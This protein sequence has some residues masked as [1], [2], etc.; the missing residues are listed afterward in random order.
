MIVRIV[1]HNNEAVFPFKNAG[2][3][4]EFY[5]VFVNNGI[6]IAQ[7][8][9]GVHTDALISNCHSIE[10]MKEAIS[11][12][13]PRERRALI[14]WEP[15]IVDSYRYKTEILSQ[16]GVIYSPSPL[17]AEKVGGKIFKW[18]Q[19]TISQIENYEDWI[20]RKNK[21][22]MVQGNKWSAQ[23]GE[24]YS[25][26]RRIISQLPK[27][28]DLYGVGWNRGIQPD[29]Y[30]LVSSLI[31]SSLNEIKLEPI[32]HLGK[33]YKNYFGEVS[34]KYDV[35]S[36]YKV[37]IVVENS[38]DYISEKLFDSVSAG[39]ICIYVG[40]PVSLFELSST[41]AIFAKPSIK[42]ITDK[43]Y[44]IVS[45]PLIEQYDI[46]QN[47]NKMLR[48]A[49]EKWNNFSVLRKLASDLINDMQIID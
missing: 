27:D 39:C 46:A 10:A 37:S 14:L 22:V 4:E 48:D 25:L 9:F 32:K 30:H 23:K 33:K 12:G 3:W 31:N 21:A 8:N 40:P 5:K 44:E 17:W 6:L 11:N 16:Y 2:P 49:S 45:L 26:R 43:F 42:D 35:L 13:V 41:V 1:G 38:Q 24:M 19:D 18:P 36:K 20:P 29:L 34:N 28:L 47:Q 15:R 7:N